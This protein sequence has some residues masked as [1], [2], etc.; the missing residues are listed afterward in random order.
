MLALTEHIILH[1]ASNEYTVW[2]WRWRCLCAG[3]ESA[4]LPAPSAEGS[5][6][7]ASDKGVE[8]AGRPEACSSPAAPAQAAIDA[9]P[10]PPPIRLTPATLAHELALTA[11]VAAFSPKNYQLWNARR[12]LAFSRGALLTDAEAD[13]ELAFSEA[14]LAQ[15]AK[16]HHA[17]MHRQAVLA[18]VWSERVA[19]DELELTTQ[20]LLDDDVRNNSV[21]AQRMFVVRRLV[22]AEVGV[23]GAAQPGA[24]LIAGGGPLKEGALQADHAIIKRCVGAIWVAFAS[25]NSLT[26]YSPVSGAAHHP[27]REVA[28][29]RDALQ[30]APSN[31]A[32]WNYLWGLRQLVRG[33]GLDPEIKSLADRVRKDAPWALP[34]QAILTR[35]AQAAAE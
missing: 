20:L 30:S 16:N 21:W 24:L 28:M 10:P 17:W 22:A 3:I 27:P 9:P 35:L 32:A 4:R 8:A 5:A 33:A 34:A 12:K 14:C 11:S 13:A 19:R 29:V 2:E 18:A 25:N 15:D 26:T 7:L 31:Q 1:V 23:P 6:E